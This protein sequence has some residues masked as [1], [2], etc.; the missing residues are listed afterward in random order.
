ML[1]VT[2]LAL[3]SLALLTIVTAA[4]AQV[5]ETPSDASSIR[6]SSASP[7]PALIGA[8]SDFSLIGWVRRTNSTSGGRQRILDLGS[9]LTVEFNDQN[10]G[11][12][13]QLRGAVST[14]DVLVP[15]RDSNAGNAVPV[16]Q[17]IL[18]ACSW[19]ATFRRL[20]G[21]AQAQNVPLAEANRSDGTWGGSTLWPVR[22]GAAVGVPGFTGSFGLVTIRNHTINRSDFSAIWGSTERH[23][24]APAFLQ[25]GAINGFPGVLWMIGH[26]MVTLPHTNVNPNAT[27]AEVGSPVTNTNL[28]V[29]NSSDGSDFYSSGAIEFVTGTWTERSPHEQGFA[30]SGFFTREVPD[31]GLAGPRSVS[32]ESPLA[33][34]LA[35]GTPSGLI[36]VIVS[37]NS[38]AVRYS[39]PF[40]GSLLEN[41]AHGGLFLARKSQIAGVIVPAVLRN[42]VPWPGF[43]DRARTIGNVFSTLDTPHPSVAFGNFGS[44]CESSFNFPQHPLAGSAIVIEDGASCIPKARPELETLFPFATTPLKVR[45]MLLKYPGSGTVSYQAE[46][47]STP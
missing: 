3:V 42:G 34:Q 19:N 28:L 29:Y 9:V 35:D 38:R 14:I 25:S 40:Y 1:R 44:H 8:T 10:R 41:W 30:W 31:L 7:P 15:L 45:A 47:A 21:W 6:F 37:A 5:L 24:F 13:F 22:L 16:N 27:G 23:Y 39:R 12:D 32:R 11:I 20:D 4:H 43:Y 46:K 26:G 2:K 36:R 33:K 17:W 18:F